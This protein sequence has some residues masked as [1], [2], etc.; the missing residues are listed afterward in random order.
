[1]V[2]YLMM[3]DGIM[4]QLGKILIEAALDRTGGK[5]Y[6]AIIVSGRDLGISWIFMRRGEKMEAHEKSRRLQLQGLLERYK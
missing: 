4:S 5:Y 2:V 1:M 3:D 6:K